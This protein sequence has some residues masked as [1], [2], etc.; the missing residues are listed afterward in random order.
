M[1][2]MVLYKYAQLCSSLEVK[3]QKRMAFKP[4]KKT[5][6]DE[7]AGGEEIEKLIVLEQY[8][9]KKG[10]SAQYRQNY[11]SLEKVFHGFCKFRGTRK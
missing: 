10:T 5:T 6:A 3:P 7:E 9:A 4:S 11:L 2:Q 8:R 1:V